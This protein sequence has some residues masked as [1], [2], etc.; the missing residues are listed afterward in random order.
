MADKSVNLGG[1][2]LF[3][4]GATNFSPQTS[5]SPH[6]RDAANIMDAVG[7]V[8]CETMINNRTEYT[9]NFAYCNAVPAI[10]TDLGTI[11]TTF[12]AVADSKLV[13]A[14]TIN[15]TSG[16][17]ATVD[18]TGHNHD[19]NAHASSDAGVA[20]VSSAVPSGAGFGVPDYGLT[21]GTD[22]TPISSTL[23]FSLNHIDEPD[24]AGEHLVGKNTT[25]R[26]EM[27]L[28]LLGVPTSVTVAAIE[29][30]LTGWTVDT[31]GGADGNQQLDTFNITAHRHYDLT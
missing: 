22:S 5:E 31:N 8:E 21:V 6:Q 16:A 26:V 29:S 9:N 2:D 10:G 23:S 11:L 12:G 30:D 27:S 4:L 19:N 1:S 14:V 18:I 15:F 3:S 20:N 17:Y 24:A 25:V 28:E 7:N 13:T